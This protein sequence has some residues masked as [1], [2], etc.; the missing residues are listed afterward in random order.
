MRKK[1]KIKYEIDP[2]NR[3]IYTRTGK[4]S[5]VPKYREII[6]GE[7]KT[8]KNNSLVYHIKKSRDSNI[9]RQVRFSGRW[10]LDKN[11]DLVFTLDE[12]HAQDAGDEITL[13]GEIK[14]AEANKLAFSVSGKNMSGQPRE[15]ILNLE[16]NWQADKY[17]RLTFNVKRN[18][19]SADA[20]T[21]KSGWSVNKKNQLVYTYEKARLKTKQRVIK[22]LTFKG[23]WDITQ[24]HRLLYVLNKRI[25]SQFD[26]EAGLGKPLARGLEYKI[27]AGIVPSKERIT[28]LGEWK[29]NTKLGVL[30]EMPYE[31]GELKRTVFG[32][33]CKL[34]K[35]GALDFKLRNE[36]GKD[37]GIDIKLSERIFGNRGEVFLR[38]VKSGQE[39]EISIGAGWEW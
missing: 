38:G 23:H 32:A 4:K 27:G 14:S 30:F 21:L 7:I 25:G 36:K 18:K 11:H 34:G 19:G 26:F 37:P 35:N 28:L 29:I 15:Y 31:K 12:K 3:L 24:K 20:L 6:D 8:D 39:K 9:P 13:T 22:T 17:N 5:N 33:S 1:E 10:S 2:N 16:G